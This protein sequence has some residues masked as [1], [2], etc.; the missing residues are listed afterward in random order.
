MSSCIDATGNNDHAVSS[1]LSSV[2]REKTET[3]H[4]V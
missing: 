1:G 4:V 3:L 2:R